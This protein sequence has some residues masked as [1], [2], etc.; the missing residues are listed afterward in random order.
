[1]CAAPLIFDQS[2]ELL[3]LHAHSHLAEQVKRHSRLGFSSAFR[4]DCC[5]L[6]LKKMIHG[7]E[8]LA[9]QVAYWCD[10]HSAVRRP[11]FRL[12][13]P[14]GKNKILMTSVRIDKYR[15]ILLTN[16]L[17]MDHDEIH[18]VLFL[19]YKDN[20]NV[21]HSVLDDH[22]LTCS[23]SIVSYNDP[24]METTH[25][26]NIILFYQFENQFF[27][28]IQQYNKTDT[29]LFDFLEF[30]GAIARPLNGSFPLLHLS[31]SFV[32]IPVSWIQHKCV[33]IPFRDSVSLSKFRIDFEHD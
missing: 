20:F 14:M 28:L 27:A 30:P 23:S 3:S 26:G 19:R 31:D 33:S 29:A 1:M 22:S 12:Q 24:R 11:E 32:V 4:F 16:L 9:T 2:I 13:N 21:Y 6:Y 18:I 10:L 15:S 7:I 25:Y 17:K 8:N 5:I